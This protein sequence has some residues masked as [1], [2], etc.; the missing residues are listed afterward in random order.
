LGDRLG[1]LLNHFVNFLFS[2]FPVSKITWAGIIGTF[3]VGSVTFGS[4]GLDV[5]TWIREVSMST[6]SSFV[7]VGIDIRVFWILL[8]WD[9]NWWSWGLW[10]IWDLNWLSRVNWIWNHW[11][12]IRCFTSIQL[13]IWESSILAGEASTVYLEVFGL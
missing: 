3:D 11:R 1:N 7:G 9:N 8:S 5:I 6:T 4:G 2:S 13:N 12:Y 10:N